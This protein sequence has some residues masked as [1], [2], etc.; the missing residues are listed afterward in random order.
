LISY[1]TV[2]GEGA[3]GAGEQSLAH[4]PSKP[5]RLTV[6]TVASAAHKEVVASS[7]T[8]AMAALIIIE[9]PRVDVRTAR[10]VRR[11]RSKN[12]GGNALL[13][14]EG[15]V[16]LCRYCFAANPTSGQATAHLGAHAFAKSLPACRSFNLCN[17][18]AVEDVEIVQ[19]RVTIAGHRQDFKQFRS[20]TAGARDLPAADH[21]GALAGLE[22]AQLRH[23]AHRKFFT[24]GLAEIFAKLSEFR[25]GQCGRS[26]LNANRWRCG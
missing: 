8:R 2:F 5:Q 22:A 21:V 12:E 15:P 10:D 24:N 16:K 14:A 23:V 11:Q 7:A 1:D 19:D 3:P 20:R 18:E 9:K 6:S 13:N 17:I 26:I 25:A 4:S